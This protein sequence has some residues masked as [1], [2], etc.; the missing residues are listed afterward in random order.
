MKDFIKFLK[1]NKYIKYLKYISK[2]KWFV[3]VEC[4]KSGL[5]LQGLL[6]DWSKFTWSEFKAYTNHF[7]GPNEQKYKDM[8]KSKGGYSKG[9]D[10]PD[11]FFDVAWL[12]HIHRNPHHW[13]YWVLIQDEDDN[14]ALEMPMK[15]RKEMY[16]DWVGAGKAQGRW[17]GEVKDWY[18]A[19]K[20]KMILGTQTR[21][22]VERELQ[23]ENS[24]YKVS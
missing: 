6:H 13:Q 20:D 1:C 14:K 22:W 16:C 2:H 21:M 18:E 19:H 5:I 23:G 9:D 15:Y 4:F 24:F 8:A 11:L 12:R 3:M 17:K 10:S 7:Y